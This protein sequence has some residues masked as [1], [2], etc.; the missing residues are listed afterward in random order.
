MKSSKKENKQKVESAKSFVMECN[1]FREPEKLRKR[2]SE[3]QMFKR[4]LKSKKA[5]D[6]IQPHVI[7]VPGDEREH[8]REKGQGQSEPPGIRNVWTYPL[9]RRTQLRGNSLRGAILGTAFTDGNVTP[10]A[11]V[12]GQGACED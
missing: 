7:R 11:T 12:S 5:E 3:G 9:E 6:E 10:W 1:L 4:I 2:K 8:C